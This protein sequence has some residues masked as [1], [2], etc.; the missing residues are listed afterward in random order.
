MSNRN[1]LEKLMD[2]VEQVVLPWP[3]I[4]YPHSPRYQGDDL[5]F[6][7]EPVITNQSDKDS[8]D[9][10]NIIRNYI[11]GNITLPPKEGIFADVSTLGDYREM[12]ERLRTVGEYFDTLPAET[13]EHFNNDPA[14]MIDAMGDETRQEELQQLGLFDAAAPDDAPGATPPPPPTASPAPSTG[15]GGQPQA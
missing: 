15:A 10:N 11:R 4:Q 7:D 3:I 13:R 8:C 6:T 1:K 14:N 5:D 12:R 2:Q 9:L